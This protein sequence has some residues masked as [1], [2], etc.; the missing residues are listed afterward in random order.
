[1]ISSVDHFFMYLLTIYVSFWKMYIQVFCPFFIQTLNLF[2]LCNILAV[3]PQTEITN[4]K[5]P[6][7]DFPGGPLVSTPC[8]QHRGHG[9]NPTCCEAWPEVIIIIKYPH[10][11]DFL[12]P[13]LFLFKYLFKYNVSLEEL[14]KGILF[15]Y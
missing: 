11:H 12:I 9:F 4:I 3:W 14:Y 2:L 13:L 6:H 10:R 5:Y 1:M 7:M 8:F 15:G